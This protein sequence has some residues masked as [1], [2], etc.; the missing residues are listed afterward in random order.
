MTITITTCGECPFCQID[1]E[2]QD[3]F[4]IHPE[5]K[6]AIIEDYENTVH[7]SCPESGPFTIITKPKNTED[8]S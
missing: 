1:R 2:W 4:C 8:E 3:L 5:N 7:P 6:H